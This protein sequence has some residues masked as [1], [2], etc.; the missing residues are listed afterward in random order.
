LARRAFAQK[1]ATEYHL[2]QLN[3][4]AGPSDTTDTDSCY[5]QALE[6]LRAMNGTGDPGVPGSA[7][8]ARSSIRCSRQ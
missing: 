7:A 6:D 5:R 1:L 2:E 4:A 8:L 3:G